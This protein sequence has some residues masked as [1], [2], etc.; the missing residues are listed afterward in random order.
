MQGEHMKLITM[1][2][3]LSIMLS[4]QV[5]YEEYFT[6]G[7]MQLNWRPW[8]TDSIGIGDSMDVVYD[9]TTPG[10][11]DWAGVIK[12]EYMSMAGLTYAGISTLTDY[13]IEAWI[14]TD[15][16]SG[17]GGPYNGIAWRMNPSTRYY[18]RLVSDFDSDSRMRLG[19]IG[20]GGMPVALRD[21]S[22]G[23]I[24]G[25]VPATSSWHKFSVTMI[26]DSIWCYY[27]DNLLP[28]CPILNDSVTQGYFGIYTFNMESTAAT[29]CDNIIVTEAI[30]SVAEVQ[31]DHVGNLVITPNPFSTAVQI[32]LYLKEEYANRI[33]HFD[34]H[35]ITGRLVRT[36]DASGSASLHRTIRWDGTNDAH[37][38]VPNGVY[39]L[40]LH[41]GDHTL[42]RKLLF[43]R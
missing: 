2:I 17:A 8:F 16:M 21:W 13:S 38:K 25:G 24:P 15:V 33:V 35:D 28:G 41:V 10:G 5:L 42:T 40:V 43:I 37:E 30:S 4:A 26:A 6:G 34:I 27:D 18:Y 11:D 31:R 1:L 22:S 7:T 9:T 29:L 36:Y 20:S 12:N 32:N 14:Y 3:A 39:L 19:F 23:E